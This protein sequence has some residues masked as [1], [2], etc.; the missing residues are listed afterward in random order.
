MAITEK[1]TNTMLMIKRLGLLSLCLFL[2]ACG[3]NIKTSNDFR[4][5]TS[6]STLTQYAFLPFE[7]NGVQDIDQDRIKDALTD[8]L[9]K[10]G[11]VA[12]PEK[13]ADVL[14]AYHVFTQ[15]K[16][17]QRVTSTGGGSYYYGRRYYGGSIGMGSTYV[18]N[19]DYK[20]GHLVVDFVAPDNRKVLYHAE[21][22]TKVGDVNTPED[23]KLL[24]VEAV[25]KMLAEYPPD[26][27]TP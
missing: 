16:Q 5:E 21:A 12:V 1:G 18:T 17:K 11:L 2:F 15:N 13:D 27:K 3:D 14:I 22:S 20:V 26:I 19:I 24:I 6:F 23:R 25:K 9:T 7:A 8:E 4:P 10:K